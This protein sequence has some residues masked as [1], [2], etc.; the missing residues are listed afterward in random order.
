MRLWTIQTE[1]AY[2]AFEQRGFLRG[3][4][5]R[6]DRGWRTAYEWMAQ[7]MALRIGK[8]PAGCSAPVWAWK[9]WL[10]RSDRPDLR[11]GAHLPRGTAGV[12]IAFDV[13][14]DQVLLSDFTRWHVVLNN[15]WLADDEEEDNVW[16]RSP[17][18]DIRGTWER[19]FDLGRGCPEYFGPVE[20]R[21][22]QAALW[23][24]EWPQVRE[25]TRFVAR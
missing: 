10:E 21:G 22:V 3:D 8:P 12:R 14:P 23:Q 15:G 20:T 7:Q 5:R 9:T 6:V 2:R 11:S 13:E 24:I 16:E 18:D 17:P 4:K 25:V 19:I 1:E